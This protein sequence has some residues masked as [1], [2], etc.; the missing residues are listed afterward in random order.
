MG[1][2]SSNTKEDDIRAYF[3]QYGKVRILNLVTYFSS[4]PDPLFIA[5]P[6]GTSFKTN[7][8]CCGKLLLNPS[9]KYS[10]CSRVD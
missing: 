5:C 4:V 9:A 7:G 1:G 10:C 6:W 2:I 3:S 8:M